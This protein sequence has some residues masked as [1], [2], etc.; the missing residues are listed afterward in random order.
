[1]N[2]GCEERG[3]PKVLRNVRG[4]KDRD[5]ISMLPY[6]SASVRC[7][8]LS[9][10]PFHPL[11]SISSDAY[12]SAVISSHSRLC[13]VVQPSQSVP[14]DSCLSK[15][16]KRFVIQPRQERMFGLFASIT[17]DSESFEWNVCFSR[18]RLVERVQHASAMPL[19]GVNL[20]LDQDC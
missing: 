2:A 20:D 12:P 8:T 4:G 1:M 16:Q 13:R 7:E 17:R 11:L 10:S 19:Y 6:H 3:L 14:L 9:F 15:T 5:V 18:A